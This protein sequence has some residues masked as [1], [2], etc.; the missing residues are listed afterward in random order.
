MAAGKWVLLEFDFS[1]YGPD[2]VET[3]WEVAVQG[4]R[5]IVAHPERLRWMA[6][7]FGLLAALARHGATFQLTAMS[8]TGEFGEIA[9]AASH[10]LAEKGFAHFV[11]SDA[12]DA[13][14]RRPGLQAARELVARNWGEEAGRLLFLDNPKAVIADLP[15]PGMP[16]SVSYGHAPCLSAPPARPLRAARPRP[17]L[18]DPFYDRLYRDGLN[19]RA[20]GETA[21]AARK[22]R[23][24]CFGMLDDPPSL[25]ACLGQLVLVEAAR[26]ETQPVRGTLDRLIELERLFQALS[27][28]P[29]GSLAVADREA[30]DDLIRKNASPQASPTSRPSGCSPCA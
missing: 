15:L 26:G 21:L 23:L 19:A 20:A 18:V 7:D 30:I 12:H 27:K 24:A 17:W 13:R 22:L 28:A 3:V 29:A 1:G 8:L 4:F 11:S 6:S 5:P 9:Q 2:P 16:G 25:A 14:L 10:A